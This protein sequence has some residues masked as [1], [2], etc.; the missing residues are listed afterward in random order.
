MPGAGT[1]A[2]TTTAELSAYLIDLTRLARRAGRCLT[3]IDR[4][5]RAWLRHAITELPRSWGLIRT[6]YGYLLLD[7]AGMAF[8]DASLSSGDWGNSD[9][10]SRLARGLD[11]PQ[12][13]AEAA[14][15]RA[16]MTRCAAPMLRRMLSRSLPGD[17]DYINVGHSNLTERVMSSVRASTCGRIIVLLHDA[18]PLDFPQTQS[19]EAP[20]R[21]RRNLSIA[22]RFADR[23]LYPSTYSKERCEGHLTQMGPVPPGRVVPL[24]MT[25]VMPC[26]TEIP[27]GVLPKG[28]FFLAIGT[29]DPRKNHLFLLDLWERMG[30]GKFSELPPLLICGAPGWE[31]DTIL[32]RFATSPLWGKGVHVYS[33]LSDGAIAALLERASGLLFPSLAEGAGLPPIEALSRGCP[34]ISA[35]LPSCREYLGDSVRYIPLEAISQWEKAVAEL[36]VGSLG[37]AGATRNSPYIRK[38]W[39]EH[40]KLALTY[41]CQ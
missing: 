23:L 25:S 30:Q 13:R 3:G 24:G 4:V 7:R 1:K 27:P 33:G 26:A 31:A 32:H 16:A 17:F 6:A 2:G 20:E 22:G 15:R 34:V 40:F 19:P 36:S 5:E 12:Q 18:I 29:V 8:L 37:G 39:R 21:Y 38:D 11:A 35:P 14:L 10:L 28:P 9:L 41:A